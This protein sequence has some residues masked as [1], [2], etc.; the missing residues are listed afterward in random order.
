MV[1]LTRYGTRWLQARERQSNKQTA[2]AGTLA[3]PLSVALLE[4]YDHDSTI[5][6][7]GHVSTVIFGKRYW[8]YAER[9]IDMAGESPPER[10]DWNT[11]FGN[12]EETR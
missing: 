11:R 9:W 12:D 7:P 10:V 1:Y 6:D 4:M 2:V 5:R 8:R 3:D